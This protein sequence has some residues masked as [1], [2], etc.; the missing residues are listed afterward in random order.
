VTY[1][2]AKEWDLDTILRLCRETGFEGVEF[3]TTHAHGVERTLSPDERRAVRKR[4]QD[5]GLLQT[6][7]GSVCEFHSP[8]P[9]VVRKH[10]DDC[11][12][13]VVLAQDIGAKGVK[14]R[15]NGLPKDVPEE[16]TLEQIGRALAEC[17]AFGRDHGVEIWVE[18]HGDQT[19]VPARMRKIMDICSHPSVGLTWNSNDTDVENGSVA[20]SFALLR[21]DIRCCHITDLRSGYPY[22]ELFSLLAQ[23]GFTGFTLCEF[24]DPVPAFNGAA[25]LRD[26]RERWESLQKG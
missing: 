8:D 21:P 7:L 22:R 9:A 19:K 1:N 11:R 25:W 4:C 5:A 2:V 23:S 18:V 20:Q 17:G 12:E 6:S 24:P 16:K 10:I 13:W 15:P 3:R 14:V 26:Y